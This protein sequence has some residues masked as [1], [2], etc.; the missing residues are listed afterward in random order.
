METHKDNDGSDTPSTNELLQKR[1]F[2]FASRVNNPFPNC[3]PLIRDILKHGLV[4]G[5][6]HPSLVVDEM[7]RKEGSAEARTYDGI[8]VQKIVEAN[9]DI[10]IAVDTDHGRICQKHRAGEQMTLGQTIADVLTKVR[11]PDGECEDNKNEGR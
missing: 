2:D 1:E 5:H 10:T 11:Y 3:A 7:V 9:G 6:A 8:T 4:N